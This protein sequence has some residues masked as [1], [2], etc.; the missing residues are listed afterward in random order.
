MAA[1]GAI[2]NIPLGV[3][4]AFK[5]G[6]ATDQPLRAAISSSRP[7]ILTVGVLEP[8]KNHVL[9]F[10]VLRRLRESG[11]QID[12]VII[13]RPGW[14]WRN[15]LER[16]QFKPLR[17]WVRIIEDVPDADLVEFYNRAAVFA[18]PSLYEGFGLPILEA[19]A[20]GAPVVSATGVVAAGSGRRRGF[21]CRPH[22]AEGFA[23]QVARVLHDPALRA[24]MVEAG[25]R[26]A[27]EFSWRRTAEQTLA[28][29]RSVCGVAPARSGT[30]TARGC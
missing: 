23:A 5:P 6:L 14:R 26:R 1:P 19:M 25:L 12:L 28:V 2:V 7:F 13:G 8:R 21:V 17:P 20:C 29:Y 10:E 16:P 4:P 3:N 27:R 24:Q 9:L 30:A 18:Y 22:D 15:P 11:E